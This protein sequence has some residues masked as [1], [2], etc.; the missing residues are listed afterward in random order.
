[1]AWAE[2]LESGRYRGRYRDAAGRKLATEETYTHKPQA[3]RAAAALEDRARRTF[4]TD[5][6]AAKRTWGEWCDEWWPTR[7][8]EEQTRITDEGRRRNH[9]DPRWADVRIGAIRRHDVNAW[10]SAMRSAGT[11]PGT[12]IPCVRLLSVSLAAA[13]DEQIILTNPA[14]RIKLPP[15]NAAIERYLTR[16]EYTLVRAELPSTLDQ[17][18]ADWLANTGMR[19]GEA[20]GVHRH[21]F[22]A[23]RGVVRV[24]EAF[25][26]K[27]GWMKAY[28]KGRRIRSV[29]VPAWLVENLVEA[30]EEDPGK[31]GHRHRG[32]QAC[33]SGLLLT[34]P[35]GGVLRTSNWSERVWAPAV[36]R[37][38]IGHCRVHDLRHTYASWLIQSGVSLARVGKLLGHVSP[39]TTQ[40]YA[41]L[42]DEGFEQVLS[43][44]PA[45]DLPQEARSA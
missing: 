24:V 15:P 44:L 7:Q 45:P 6:D 20:A 26:E 5:P 25:E 34:G 17:L 18:I 41:H 16:E 39:V 40:R 32:G 1:M 9:L 21:R 42:E 27:T 22:D 30:L 38:G 19:W 13:V 23:K 37:A 12:I 14:A 36:A 28:P 43:A 11:R 29:P 10:V 33:R 3:V 8:V 35:R 4:A 2:Q 31:C